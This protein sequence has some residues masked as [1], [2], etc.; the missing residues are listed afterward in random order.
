[1][2][3]ARERTMMALT[4]E[5]EYLGGVCYAAQGPD[6][7]FPDWPPQPDRVFSA[8]VATWGAH[9]EPDDERHAL[10]WLEELPSSPLLTAADG[11][12]RVAH[13]V[14][15]PPNDYKTPPNELKKVKWYREFLSKGAAPPKKGGHKNLW[16]Q[17]WSVMPDAR[18]RFG[19][20]DRRFPAICLD[21]SVVRFFWSE[22]P[23]EAILTALKRLASDTSYVGHSASLTRCRFSLGD[24][25]QAD[26]LQPV[27]RRIYPGR[28][29]E[30]NAAWQRFQK[31]AD[32]KDR[33][34]PGSLVQEKLVA[35]QKR[36]NIFSDR[37]LILEHVDGVMPDIRATAIVAR[38]IRTALMS[39]YGQIGEQIPAC[40]S[41]HGTDGSPTKAPHLAIA[42]LTFSGFPYADGRVLGFALIPPTDSHLLENATFLKVLRQLANLD[43]HYGRR[44]LEVKSAEGAAADQAFMLKLSPTFEAPSGR[45]SLDPELYIRRA[46]R[47]ATVTPVV[48]D[49]YLK[50]RGEARLDEISE[51]ICTACTRIGLP[52]PRAIYPAKH[53]VLEG[54]PSAYPSGKS[55]HWMNW[56][57]P[58]SIAGRQLTHAVIDFSETV[59]GPL[60]LGAGRFLGMGLCRPLD[61]EKQ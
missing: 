9:G 49:R 33:P 28:L 29:E 58:D 19:L 11:R 52:E 23:N 15:V 37:W 13:S 36:D 24:L 17:S 4:L 18:K 50:K 2:V 57:L 3:Q 59:E 61:K 14:Y 43:D 34:S 5:I 35:S 60:I 20:K 51:Q 38:R 42:P 56:R 10:E 47:F 45:R 26:A 48:L 25:K 6:S 27:R 21:D 22:E 55:P 53:P 40:V 39:G 30:L 12:V 32:K 41:G 31:S 1:M 7:E 8:L 44:I 16:Q 46:R 54:A